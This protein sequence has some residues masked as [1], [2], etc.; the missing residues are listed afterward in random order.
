M[1]RV[2]DTVAR[3][4][5]VA[6]VRHAFGMP[7]GEVVTLVDAL[8]E[9][10]I[11]FILA[12]HETAAAI[13]AAGAAAVTGAPGLLVTTL[14]PGL[15]NAVNGIADAAQERAPLLVISG[16]VERGI[17]G[18]YTHQILDHAA[19]LRP[20]VK[21]SFEIEADGAAAVVARA[22]ALAMA[23]PC[24]PVHLDLSPAV[25]AAPDQLPRPSTV[26]APAA[27]PGIDPADPAIADIR[28]LVTTSRRPVLVAGFEA[29]RTGAVDALTQIA[30]RYG[31]P[32]LT[33]YKAKGVVDERHPAALGAAGLS[34]AADRIL[35]DLLARA[36]LVL[37]AGYDPIE[38]RQGWLEP[39]P[40]A[41]HVVELTAA[42]PDHGMHRVDQRLLGPVGELLNAIFVDLLPRRLW[43]E[44]E[45]GAARAKL[46]ARFAGPDGWGPHGV[47]RELAATLPLDTT[48]TVDS[49]AHRILFSQ[50]WQARW[51]LEVLQSAGFCTMN[52][53][54]PLAIGVQAAEPGR[55]VVAV[56]GD[57]GLE[58]GLGELGTLRDEGLR[59]I[60]VV[61]QDES[62]ALIE[63]KQ[64]QAGLPQLGVRLG[65]TDLPA[66]A[67]AFGGEGS[68]V[69]STDELREALLEA[70][71][72]PGFSLIACRIRADSYVDA[73]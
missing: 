47:F 48:L 70:L 6:G 29:A 58:M 69:A 62:L 55:T 23:P 7:G 53:A 5:A 30:D 41:A 24:G 14:G 27:S 19:L 43:P 34:P 26:T 46:A 16:V 15:A 33:T 49:G 13:M 67:R 71:A 4:L 2:A 12:R 9:A 42:P 11:R 28:R 64:R 36:D 60:L 66:V 31:I 22:I 18:R 61:L 57:G 50:M 32:M 35:L 63:L 39:F 10:G 51:P 20:L 37:L 44:G 65:R 52:A 54:L 1:T 25:A 3:G 56:L 38:M 73:F 45:P 8:A 17:R 40:A 21:A 72:A 68:E 59:V